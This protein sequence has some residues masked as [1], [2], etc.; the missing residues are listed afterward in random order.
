MSE[1]NGLSTIPTKILVPIDFSPSSHAALETAADFAQHF[2]AS[3]HLV[4][5]IPMFPSATLPDFIPEAKFLAETRK[6]ADRHFT[7][8]QAD[9]AGKGIKV[10]FS[11]EVGDD[12]AGNILDVVE[13]ENADMVVIS[14]HG[15]TGW[16]PL[17]F[18]SI[19][20][21]V[22]KLV[23]CPVLLL[24]TPKPESSAKVASGRLMEWW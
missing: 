22:L 17:V 8:C 14:T 19:A 20:E 1:T 12:V 2:D 9:L 23:H 18:G 4:H 13:R 11:I 24:R 3:I 6:E 5:V 10:S 7:A 15:L 16:H 21:K